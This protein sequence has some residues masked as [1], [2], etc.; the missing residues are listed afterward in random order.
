MSDFSD[1][2]FNCD[3]SH[4]FSDGVTISLESSEDMFEALYSNDSDEG[5]S[6]SSDDDD[7]PLDARLETS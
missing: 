7:V 5:I 6:P 3:S 4:Q 2:D 1:S